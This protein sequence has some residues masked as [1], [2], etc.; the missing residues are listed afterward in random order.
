MSGDL[1]GD[2]LRGFIEDRVRALSAEA[3]R[4][5]HHAD[6]VW[7]DQTIADDLVIEH[8]RLR[9]EAE[10][11]WHQLVLDRIGKLTADSHYLDSSRTT[12]D[13]AAVRPALAAQ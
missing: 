4:F 11:A 12:T 1:D 5:E 6:R 8:A 10:L 9:V 7:P 2:T 13:Q 3:A